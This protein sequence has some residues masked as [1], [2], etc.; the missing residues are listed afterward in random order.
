LLTQKLENFSQIKSAYFSKSF[1]AVQAGTGNNFYTQ[2][3]IPKN[4]DSL[5][6]LIEDRV[7]IAITNCVSI[8]QHGSIVDNDLKEYTQK[9]GIKYPVVSTLAHEIGIRSAI[10]CK[11]SLKNLGAAIIPEIK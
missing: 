1:L 4:M 10:S 11:N 5:Q 2:V 3:Y 9:I 6:G 8:A 7:R